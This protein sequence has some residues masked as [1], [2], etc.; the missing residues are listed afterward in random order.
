LEEW[1]GWGSGLILLPTFGVQAYRQW[2]SRDEP[3]PPLSLWFFAMAFLGTGGQ[4]IYSSLVGNKVYIALNAILTV[5]NGLGL[6]IAI[7]RKLRSGSAD[8]SEAT[9]DAE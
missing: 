1:I 2:E 8:P 4:L 5:T 9:P 3:L 7:R 6:A